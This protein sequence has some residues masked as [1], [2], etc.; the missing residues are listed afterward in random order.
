M[1]KARIFTN[2]FQLCLCL[3]ILDQYDYQTLAIDLLR[4]EKFTK[5]ATVR[6]LLK[7][8]C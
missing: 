8:N 4:E 3:D 6:L 2:S 7:F 5:S 1:K